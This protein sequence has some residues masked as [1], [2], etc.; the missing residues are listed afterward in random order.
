MSTAHHINCIITPKTRRPKNL[1]FA[2]SVPGLKSSRKNRR[3]EMFF[4]MLFV[5]DFNV[6]SRGVSC[7][8][9]AR[10]LNT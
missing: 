4:K 6:D 5:L 10:N 8:D 2:K 7:K 3:N 1:K 9:T